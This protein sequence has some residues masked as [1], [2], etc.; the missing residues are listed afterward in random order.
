MQ[1]VSLADWKQHKLCVDLNRA[2]GVAAE[3]VS[4]DLHKAHAA[5]FYSILSRHVV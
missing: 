2:E 5:M 1:L 4:C 3:I